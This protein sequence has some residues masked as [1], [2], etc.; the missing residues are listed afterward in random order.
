MSYVNYIEKTHQYYFRIGHGSAYRYAH[1]E[2]GPFAALKKPVADSR[3]TMISSAGFEIIPSD[4]PE[5]TPFKGINIGEKDQV[6]VFPIASGTPKEK[7]KYMTGAHNRAESDMADIDAFFPI[8]RLR[9][10]HAE[11]VIGGLA[12]NYLRIRPSYSTTKTLKLD[13]PE[14]LRRCREEQ[15]DVALLVP[16]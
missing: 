10:L 15:V 8:T 3:L 4:G 5:P 13:A 12:G 9:E 6:E 2:D 16:V 11:G 14:V 1:N 7:L